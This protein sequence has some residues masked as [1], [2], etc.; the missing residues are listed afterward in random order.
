ML[1]NNENCPFPEAQGD[2]FRLSWWS[3]TGR[4]IRHSVCSG[5]C[6]SSSVLFFLPLCRVKERK[7]RWWPGSWFLAVRLTWWRSEQSSRS[8]TKDPCTRPSQWVPVCVWDRPT[9]CNVPHKQ[10]P[11][12]T[13]ERSSVQTR[14]KNQWITVCFFNFGKCIWQWHRYETASGTFTETELTN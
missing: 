5:V 14:W 1:G 13:P 12:N 6:L 11:V 3:H 2:V 7:R 8:S 9:H 10:R 4:L